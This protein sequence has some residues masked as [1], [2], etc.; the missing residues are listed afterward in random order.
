MFTPLQVTF[1]FK[2]VW[3]QS[4]TVDFLLLSSTLPISKSQLFYQALFVYNVSLLDSWVGN[5]DY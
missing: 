4:L 1:H 3:D 5:P 2:I